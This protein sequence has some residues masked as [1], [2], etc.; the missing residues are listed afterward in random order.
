MIL[1]RGKTKGI[2]PIHNSSA[3]T[4]SSYLQNRLKKTLPF[5]QLLKL[6]SRNHAVYGGERVYF[7][8]SSSPELKPHLSSEEGSETA[9]HEARKYFLGCIHN[10]MHP[11]KDLYGKGRINPSMCAGV[12]R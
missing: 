6:N 4:Q 1:N 10:M 3:L 11:K 8:L 12:R 5:V 2:L 7:H 9:I